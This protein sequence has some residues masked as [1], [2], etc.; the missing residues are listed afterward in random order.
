MDD[1]R[2]ERCIDR[3]FEAVGE[4]DAMAQAIGDFRPFFGAQRVVFQ[5]A[6][7][8]RSHQ[9]LHFV[10]C[11]VPPESLVEYHL[12]YAVEDE[13]VKATWTANL[14][15]EGNVVRGSALVPPEELRKTRFWTGFL[16][17]YGIHD[18]LGGIVHVPKDGSRPPSF[19]S[20][21]R[22]LDVGPYGPQDE[23]TLTNLL[24]HLRR[25]LLTHQRLAPKIAIGE[26][27]KELF[28]RMSLPMLLVDDVGRIVEANQPAE[29][30]VEIGSDLRR[31]ANKLEVRE[32]PGWTPIQRLL[33]MPGHV[34]GTL[35]RLTDA[36]VVSICRSRA[37]MADGSFAEHKVA[38]A[39]SLR[40]I[41]LPQ[42]QVLV[43]AKFGLSVAE[44]R[45]AML[46]AK[47]LDVAEI[48]QQE[49]SK[50]TTVRTHVRTLLLKTG[51]SR[52]AEML[53]TLGGIAGGRVPGI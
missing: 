27:L 53:L 10:Q 49:G 46:I 18:V 12:M 41:C 7:I 45:V 21:H 50:V 51:T 11:D 3:L 1:K 29:R 40:P 31:R 16:S 24:P 52:Q 35:E 33:E 38:A 25:A 26:T 32:V 44:L 23:Q 5:T 28:D 4:E 37:A 8:L 36:G 6:T 19:V 39:V 9:S 15:I 43:K 17:R 2:W 20:Y 30:L 42:D 13:W 47:G 14:F 22:T 34:P 48:A